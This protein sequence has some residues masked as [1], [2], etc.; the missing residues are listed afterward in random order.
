MLQYYPPLP[1]LVHDLH[2][3]IH[4][5]IVH[6]LA[7][8]IHLSVVHDLDLVIYLISIPSTVRQWASPRYLFSSSLTST[9]RFIHLTFLTLTSL[10]ILLGF[11]TLTPRNLQY[12][13]RPQSISGLD[14]AFSPAVVYDR[15]P[16]IHLFPW[17]SSCDV[18][19][20]RLWP[21]L[22]NHNHEFI[23]R[24]VWSKIISLAKNVMENM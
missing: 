13:P 11:M 2:P 5:S 14:P 1:A 12:L 22:C 10:F 4:A 16:T 20:C 6:N 24:I 3:T 21:Q 17:L 15:D 9:T 19:F 7:R 23:T 8:T 18:F